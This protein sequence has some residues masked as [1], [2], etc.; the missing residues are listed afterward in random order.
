MRITLPYAAATR[1][2]APAQIRVCDI[3]RKSRNSSM[4]SRARAQEGVHS[5]SAVVALGLA[6]GRR[7]LALGSMDCRGIQ[8]ALNT[9]QDIR[10]STAAGSGGRPNKAPILTQINLLLGR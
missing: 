7:A 8:F 4:I 1:P 10:C 2:S 3:V 9:R 5:E 6:G